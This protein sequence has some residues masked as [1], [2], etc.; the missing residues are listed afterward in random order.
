MTDTVE[1]NVKFNLDTHLREVVTL[2]DRLCESHPRYGEL[3]ARLS[4]FL[5]HFD[6]QT[7]G[8]VLPEPHIVA[9]AKD[10]A[11]T[12]LA[13]SIHTSA[14]SL[15]LSGTDGGAVTVTRH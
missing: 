6:A 3:R 5:A 8:S 13:L 14:L 10:I 15:A 4:E 12:A 11:A 2:A 7:A 9:L 1:L